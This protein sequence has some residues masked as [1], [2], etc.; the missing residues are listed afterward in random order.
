MGLFLFNTPHLVFLS[1]ASDSISS[2]ILLST[3]NLLLAIL[4]SVASCLSNLSLLLN[5]SKALSWAIFPSNS[6]NL[7]EVSL[8]RACASSYCSLDIKD[9]PTKVLYSLD[10]LSNPAAFAIALNSLLFTVLRTCLNNSISLSMS[11]SV[12][13]EFSCLG[14]IYFL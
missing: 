3:C 8:L 12:T 13:S 6:S 4:I 10:F 14:S 2:I 7:E 5:W 9:N 11:S 1:S